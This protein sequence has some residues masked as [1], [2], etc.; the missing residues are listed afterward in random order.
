MPPDDVADAHSPPGGSSPGG[1]SGPGVAA[2]LAA[3]LA[4][5]DRHL[6]LAL[7]SAPGSPA[8]HGGL[9]PLAD[10]L[11][12]LVARSGKLDLEVTPRS[13]EW[14]GERVY[15]VQTA[16][17]PGERP[18]LEHE[19][20]WLLHRDGIRRIRLR[21]GLEPAEVRAFL[22]ALAA[23][24]VGS[25]THA[26]LV[27]RV[28]DAAPAHLWL[29]TE[30]PGAAR[31]DPLREGRDEP[32]P[33]H[34]P[35]WPL[36]EA[37]AVDVAR[38][39]QELRHD[40]DESVAS[41]REAWRRERSV[42][43]EEAFA[44]FAAE[45]RA[46]DA[47]PAMREALAAAV[48]TWIATAVQRADWAQALRALEQLARVDP[49]RRQADEFLA[50][51]LGALDGA[52]LAARLDASGVADQGRMFAFAVEA[53][54]PALPLLT[55]VLARS[56]K[57]RVRAGAT[58]ALA[59]AFADDPAPLAAWLADPRWHVVRNV[60][61]AL[62]QIGGPAV[63]PLL[64]HALRHLDPRVRRAAVHALGQVPPAWRRPVLVAQLDTQDPRLLAG[65]LAMLARDPDTRVA[66]S[67]LARVTAPEFVVRAEDERVL[68]LESLPELAG[69]FAVPVLAGVLVR[70]GWFAQ[71]S[72][73]RTAAAH[74]LRSLGSPAARRALEQ[75]LRHRSGAVREACGQ[76]LARRESA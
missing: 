7:R 3:W 41:L 12:A 4:D 1:T 71:P 2:E 5:V 50:H 13:L 45:V 14:R 18:E 70:G 64:A 23:A 52:G 49:D 54:E 61:F 24:M 33:G 35:D 16:E 34:V 63:V 30:E 68:L 66:E 56:Q 43:F 29:V 9:E 72:A 37:P 20:S 62:G 26:D 8:L 51:A 76:A 28:W 53:G 21:P 19:L 59:W 55:S 60:V 27:T 17:V 74:A 58:T 65:V 46:L 11:A 57:A 42:P 47:R 69:E 39:W 31:P 15:H 6:G 40:E 67:V 32:G 48:A 10:A 73:E 22:F 36:P 44:T 75:G 38:L 25:G